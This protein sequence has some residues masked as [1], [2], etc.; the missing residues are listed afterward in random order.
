MGNEL[1]E[2]RG[3]LRQAEAH[4]ALQQ[5]P[6]PPPTQRPVAWA[7]ATTPQSWNVVTPSAAHTPPRSDMHLF[8]G[9][10][11]PLRTTEDGLS[12]TTLVPIGGLGHKLIKLLYLTQVHVILQCIPCA[13]LLGL[14]MIFAAS[15]ACHIC[16]VD[17]S[18]HRSDIR[19]KATE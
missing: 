2:A 8:E 11:L 4:A 7:E 5:Q 6:C 19:R 16:D 17:Q 1:E 10:T 15:E 3:E 9:G 18:E 12:P 13:L 14:V